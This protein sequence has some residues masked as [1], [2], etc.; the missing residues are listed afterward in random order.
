V[1]CRKRRRWHIT[2]IITTTVTITTITITAGGIIITAIVAG[3][4]S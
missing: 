3:G 4:T 2:T 1:R